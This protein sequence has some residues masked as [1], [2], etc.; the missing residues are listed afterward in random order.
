MNDM[1]NVLI[2]AYTTIDTKIM[3]NVVTR[4]VPRA[5]DR[6]QRFLDEEGADEA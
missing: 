2:H 5:R 3:W 1:R 4:D 6:L